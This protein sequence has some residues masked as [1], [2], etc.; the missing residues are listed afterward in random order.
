VG[1]SHAIGLLAAGLLVLV[2]GVPWPGAASATWAAVA[3]L[4]GLAGVL[5]FYQALALG[6]MSLAAPLVAVIAAA[7]PATAGL[8][9]GDRV[10][11]VQVAGLGC[12]LISVVVVSRSGAEP[13]SQPRS[14]ETV[15]LLPLIIVAGLAF[16]AFYLAM[17]R[18]TA[19]GGGTAW[20]PLLF[21]RA[22]TVALAFGILLARHVRPE[23]GAIRSAAIPLLAAGLGDLGGNGFFL[24]ATAAAPFSLAVILSSLYPVV[25][26]LLAAILLGERLG[27]LQAAGVG[28]ALVGVVL[29]AL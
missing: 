21:S 20:W 17:G 29:I 23:S 24:L 11:L 28:L 7:I 16:A 6:E 14:R 19:I 25:T 12:G 27:R 4:A 5:G 3:G 22:A 10:D 1:L 15:R 8:V 9:L 2:A 13:G 26:V 18:A